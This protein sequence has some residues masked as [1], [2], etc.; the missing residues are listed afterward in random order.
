VELHIVLPLPGLQKYFVDIAPAPVFSGLERLHHRMMDLMKV[1][2]RVLVFRRVTAANVTT[3]EAQTKVDPGVVHFKA[4]LAAF[5]AWG[6]LLDFL[7]VG[8]GLCHG[9]PPD[10]CLTA[11]KSYRLSTRGKGR[12]I[13]KLR[14]GD[15]VFG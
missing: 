4:F 7:Q 9:S 8:T 1:L 12:R 14:G 11:R 6:D 5:A 3:L 2:G 10:F 13:Q 15:G